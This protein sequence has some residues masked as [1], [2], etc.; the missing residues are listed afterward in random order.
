MEQNE[1]KECSKKKFSLKNIIR[2]QLREKF[3]AKYWVEILENKIFIHDENF[4]LDLRILNSRT[5][6]IVFRYF[7]I[8]N[9]ETII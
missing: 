1:F 7:V 3:N 5:G 2:G 6:F 9:Q 8:K 4:S